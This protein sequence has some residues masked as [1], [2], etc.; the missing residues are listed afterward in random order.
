MRIEIDS[1]L[2][3]SAQARFSQGDDPAFFDNEVIDDPVAGE[4]CAAD[5]GVFSFGGAVVNQELPPL[6]GEDFCEAVSG[7]GAGVHVNN[8]CRVPIAK[9]R[10]N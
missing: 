8:Q 4:H 7:R 6:F 5:G 2:E 10:M 3:N 9:C 1:F